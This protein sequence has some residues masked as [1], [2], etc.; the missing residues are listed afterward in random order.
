[1]STAC[2]GSWLLA[3][4]RS[5]RRLTTHSHTPAVGTASRS[6]SVGERGA[7][8]PR[9]SVVNAVATLPTSRPHFDFC[10]RR[11]VSVPASDRSTKPFPRIRSS[12]GPPAFTRLRP[13]RRAWLTGLNRHATLSPTNS[14]ALEPLSFQL[15]SFTATSPSGTYSYGSARL[16]GVI[17]FGNTHLDSRPYELAIARTYRA[18]EMRYGYRERL[19]QLG[20]PLSELEEGAI[21]PIHRAFRVDMTAWLLEDGRRDGRFNT[22]MIARQLERTDVDRP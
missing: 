12:T 14:A 7:R 21:E 4:G 6:S 19:E 1:M 3:V 11:S 9:H 2:S 22:Q 18:P 20:W 8:S 5:L 13:N 15:P 17:D 10:Q 16:T